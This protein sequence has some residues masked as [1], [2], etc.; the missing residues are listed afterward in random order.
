MA[1]I[2]PGVPTPR[3]NA[4]TLWFW[5][6]GLQD[7]T[8]VH[9]LAVRHFDALVQAAA[10]ERDRTAPPGS[11]ADGDTYVI[12][13]TPAA[14]GAWTGQ[15]GNIA[16]WLEDT[17]YFVAPFEGLGVWIEE[18][19]IVLFWQGT[20]WVQL[21][22]QMGP[23]GAQHVG[24]HW[25]GTPAYGN[26][27]AVLL[28]ESGPTGATIGDV[29]AVNP[30][31]TG[32]AFMIQSGT[33][34]D[35]ALTT[36]V[37]GTSWL[38]DGE[39]SHTV[40]DA[41]VPANRWCWV[42]FVE[43]PTAGFTYSFPTVTTG[44]EFLSAFDLLGGDAQKLEVTEIANCNARA[45]T[46]TN[47]TAYR[48]NHGALDITP[49]QCAVSLIQKTFGSDDI[50]MALNLADENNFH[51]VYID[52][53]GGAGGIVFKYVG[54]SFGLMGTFLPQLDMRYRLERRDNL[55]WLFEGGF[56]NE[57]L[58][59]TWPADAALTSVQVGLVHNGLPTGG[60]EIS[61]IGVHEVAAETGIDYLELF[62]DWTVNP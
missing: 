60:A 54:G 56:G 47:R 55:I 6:L 46:G 35:T 28:F 42:E 20:V 40:L 48:W 18:E 50:A 37:T 43:E 31:N 58:I 51:A 53:S 49:T 29:R 59:N 38:A 17:W 23:P 39:T 5:Q 33:S 36:H 45:G 10:K 26:D 13:P 3:H 25:D 14:T 27:G 32:P 41:S 22:G 57:V 9:N 7:Q 8:G 52:N 34:R 30:D 15:N 12:P 24:L 19:D 21:A 4:P 2:T 62:T 11:P 44:L 16:M 1:L 61:N